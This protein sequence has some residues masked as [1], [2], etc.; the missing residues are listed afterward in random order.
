MAMLKEARDDSFDLLHAANAELADGN[1][2]Q[3]RTWND[4]GVPPVWVAI[5]FSTRQFAAGNI[6]EIVTETPCRHSG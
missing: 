1:L 4:M 2:C 6:V 3:I 5:N